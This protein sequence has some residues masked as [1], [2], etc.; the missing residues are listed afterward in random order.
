MI[1]ER[2]SLRYAPNVAYTAL[3]HLN[4]MAMRW[5]ADVHQTKRRPIDWRGLPRSAGRRRH[6]PKAQRQ[7][8]PRHTSENPVAYLWS[9]WKQHELSNFCPTRFGQLSHGALRALRSY[10]PSPQPSYGFLA[11][12]GAVFF[13]IIL[14]NPR[15]LYFLITLL[16]FGVIII[17]PAGGL[18]AP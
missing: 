8:L 18:E 12:S 13:V 5:L 15:S 17:A 1:T 14:C 4:E 3:D 9:H 7:V 2:R 6:H 16:P 11:P 10:A